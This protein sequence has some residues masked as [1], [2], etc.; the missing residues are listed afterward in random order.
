MLMAT[1]EV[2]VP[3]GMAEK[4]FKRYMDRIS[5]TRTALARISSLL[6]HEKASVGPATAAQL[7]SVEN[8]WRHLI[9]TYGVYDSTDIAS[10]RGAKHDN[11]SVATYLTKTAG[12]IGFSRGRMKLYPKF[13]F[14]GRNVHPNWSHICQ[15]LLDAGWHDDDI[16]LWM[17]SA[18]AAFN[19]QEPAERIDTDAHTL[20]EVVEQEAAGI[21]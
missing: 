17:V 19:G 13:Q 3:D 5:S 11:R 16:L 2:R 1:I 12:L 7:V 18:N 8:L 10:L 20:R 14:K 6:E 9:N 21:W 15:P 4:E